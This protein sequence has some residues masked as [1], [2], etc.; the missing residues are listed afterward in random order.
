[1]K[2]I[3]IIEDNL[4]VRENTAEIVE[5]A[6]YEVISAE[7]GK[8]GVELALKEKPDL[9]VCD[10]MMPVLD[11]YGVFHLLSKHN[12]TASIPFIFLT[13]KSEKADFR[14]GMEMGADDY[15]MKPFDG[16]ELLH[17]IEVRLKKNELLKQQYSGPAA[18]DSFLHDVQQ[19]G[20]VK[21][22]SDERETATYSRKVHI[23]KEGQR[24]RVVY[25]IV[26]GKVKISKTNDDGKE[27]ITSIHGP[28]EYFGYTAILED[29][30]YKE[31]AQAL[32]DSNLM[33]IPREDFLQLISS[34]IEIARAFIKIITQNIVEK[35]ESLLNLAY[36]SLRKKVAYGLVQLLEKYKAEENERPV[37]NL[38][39]EN[40][41]HSI[42]I[43]TESLIRTLSDFKDEKL[44]D[45]QTGKVI[46]IDEKKLRTLPY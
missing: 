33:L 11:G 40:M 25:T 24:P 34:D 7:N 26:S 5:L 1:M 41:A 37:L 6:N 15:I 30:N 8:I 2:K 13:A 31:D 23:Y 10:I 35:E 39:R 27:F 44:V 12:E 42:G 36:S 4:E 46:I 22:V 14:K 43:A 28:G 18:L 19:T 9:I 16:I 21:L 17:A 32:E 20:K 45:L 38:S 29:I 3:L